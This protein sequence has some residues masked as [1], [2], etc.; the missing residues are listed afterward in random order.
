MSDRYALFKKLNMTELSGTL[1]VR[2]SARICAPAQVQIERG[3][4]IKMVRR[5]IWIVSEV[6]LEVLG[7]QL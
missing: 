6:T 4:G 3:Y 1:L 2:P 5:E 7:R